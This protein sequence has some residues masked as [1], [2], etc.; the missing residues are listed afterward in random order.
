MFGV[1]GFRWCHLEK[2]TALK[3]TAN[4]DSRPALTLSLATPTTGC[5]GAQLS[6]NR[7]SGFINEVGQPHLMPC[8]SPEDTSHLGESV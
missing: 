7:G 6:E 5:N 8:R 1:G 4:E 3:N 2:E